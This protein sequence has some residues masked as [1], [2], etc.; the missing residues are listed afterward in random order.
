MK[1]LPIARELLLVG[2]GHTHS[3]FLKKFAM[4]PIDGVK[5]TLINP[6]GFSTYSGMVPGFIA[7]H[8]GL[9]DI[10]INLRSLCRYAD[11]DFV[12]G[13]IDGID[14][15]KDR[16]IVPG[17]PDLRYDVLSLDVGSGRYTD[18]F[19]RPHGGVSV[20]PINDFVPSWV[21]I[22]ENIREG[23]VKKIGVV[24]S[25]PGGLELAMAI[26]Y[27]LRK[28]KIGFPVSINLI[29]ANMEVAET[30]NRMFRSK[31]RS[32]LENKGIVVHNDFYAV[33]YDGSVLRSSDGKELALDEV[34]WVAS[35]K[36]HKW[37]SDTGLRH[38]DDGFF[39]VTETLQ[40][41]SRPN[42]FAVGD[43]ATLIREPFP[44]A[45]VYAVRQAPI[46]FHNIAAFF[47]GKKM[48]AFN[49]QSNLLSLVSA[50][51]RS[52]LAARGAFYFSGRL[53]WK[54]KDWIDRRFMKQ[55]NELPEMKRQRSNVLIEEF[56]S[57]HF[58]GGCGSKVSS[59]TLTEVLQEIM[60]DEAPLGDAA[61]IEVPEGK[62]LL[63]SV[64]HFRSFLNDSY[65]QARIAV[66]HAMSDLYACGG[67]PL[68]VMASITL[69]F[70][71]PEIS[72]NTLTQIMQ[73]ILDQLDI[74][75]ARLIG[76][77]TS[78]GEE[79]SIGFTVNGLASR[80]HLREK[81]IR[82]AGLSVILT[83]GLGIGAIFA[84]DMQNRCKE[85]WVSSA[86]SSM[87]KSNHAAS[88]IAAD[89]G[90]EFCTDV[91]GFG[92]AGHLSEMIGCDIGVE[93]L[94]G[95]VPLLPGAEEIINGLNIL[96]SLHK[97][98]RRAAK[99]VDLVQEDDILYD[100]QTSGGLLMAIEEPRAL[101]LTQSL[102][103]NGYLQASI[104]GQSITKEG[105]HITKV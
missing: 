8:Y 42:I 59:D 29:T 32:L 102:R 49:P 83:K 31:T 63:Q 10:R 40:A 3:I 13:R 75:G 19:G 5:V 100:P 48:K 80:D 95:E 105:L 104:I 1:K 36:A 35:S 23:R 56:D 64:D 86:I 98:N 99:V 33:E 25:G 52:A 70:S 61:P 81:R 53:A 94:L 57:I 12:E 72:R 44:K 28:E 22:L 85:E 4:S 101:E 89:F 55:F 93:L 84:A 67:E 71:N 51:D 17:R 91:T 15:Q 69:P 41:S 87:L 66:C 14:I 88:E 43:C 21:S 68:S 16:V 82:R 2:G 20:K 37:P 74:E 73:G 24:G 18:A 62:I 65:L 47:L 77:H 60:G 7:G 92:L 11:A 6:A 90:V 96:S 27:R 78:E 9:D 46:L 103:I 50:G 79:L 30:Y 38:D 45:G 34:L 54:W 76:G 58:C 39:A 97:S 26:E